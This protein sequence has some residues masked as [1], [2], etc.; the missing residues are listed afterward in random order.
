[1]DFLKAF[2]MKDGKFSK[3]ATFASVGTFLVLNAY[4]MS[5]FAG[6]TIT[7]FDGA[8]GMVLP[9]FDASAA[10]ALLAILNGAYLGNNAIKSK[11]KLTNAKSSGKPPQ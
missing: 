8:V 9:A 7:L 6:S 1:M 11:E 3:T 5:W 2:F 10:V 4:V